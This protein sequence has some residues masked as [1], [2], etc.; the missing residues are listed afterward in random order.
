MLQLFIFFISQNYTY[1]LN[2]FSRAKIQI[3]GIIMSS[4]DQGLGKGKSRPKE[5]QLS[6]PLNPNSFML[7]LKENMHSHNCSQN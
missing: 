4:N 7:E 1:Y 3:S 2:L 6:P 5:S